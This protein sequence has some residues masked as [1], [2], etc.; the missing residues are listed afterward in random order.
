MKQY[1]TL[2][3]LS[4]A[5]VAGAQPKPNVVVFYADDF[6]WGDLRHHNKNLEHFRYTPN[7]DRM[8]SE[9]IEG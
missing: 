2:L 9:G 5:A 8:F 6:G 1:G 4:V 3:L 7:L